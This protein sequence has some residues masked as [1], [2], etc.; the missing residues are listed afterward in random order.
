MSI[1]HAYQGGC[2]CLDKEDACI[3]ERALMQGYALT[4]YQESFSTNAIAYL[5]DWFSR[6]NDH[7]GCMDRAKKQNRR[8]LMCN[9]LSYRLLILSGLLLVTL[10]RVVVA[11]ENFPSDALGASVMP[12]NIQFTTLS[13]SDGLSQ[14]AINSIVQDRQG[15]IWIGTQEGLNRYDGYEFTVYQSNPAEPGS[16][17]HDWVWTV[18]VDDAGQLWVGTDGGGLNR[19]EPDTG[20]F[21]HFRHNPDDSTSLSGNRVR[22]IYQDRQGFFWIGTDGNG[23]NRF[24]PE[25]GSFVHYRHDPTKSDSLANDKVLA[26]YEDNAGMMWIGTEGGL[27]RFYRVSEKFFHYAND[28]SRPDSLSDDRVRSL[29]EDS[30]GQFW[31]GTENGLNLLQTDGSFKRFQHNPKHPY[32]LSHNVVRTLFQDNSGALWV[33]TE[34][35]LDEWRPEVQGFVHNSHEPE[36]PSSI[37]NDRVTTVF[38]DNGGVLWIGT[39]NGISRWNYISDAFIY[40]KDDTSE[41]SGLSNNL[42]TGISE[43]RDGSVWIGTYGG[44]LNRLDPVSGQVVRFRHDPA[45]QNTLSDDRVMS[46]FT[47]IDGNVWI[48]TRNAGLNRLNLKTGRFTHYRHDPENKHTLSGNG[49][50]AIYGDGDGTLWVGVYDGG[51]NRLDLNSGEFFAFRHDP[52]DD[53][54]LSSDRVLSISAGSNG[55]LWIGTEDGGVNQFNKM[56][57]SFTQYRHDPEDTS[58]LSSDTAWDILEGRDGSLYVATRD[59]GFNRWLPENRKAGKAVFNRYGKQNGLISNLIYGALEDADGILWMSSNRGLIRLDPRNGKTRVFDKKNGLQGYEFN[60]GAHFRSLNGSLLFGGTD[61]LVMFHP[62]RVRSNLHHP[63]VSVTA[64]LHLHPV[65]TG[66]SS[67]AQPVDLTIGYLDYSISFEFTALDYTSSDKNQY[68]YMLEGFDNEWLDPGRFRRVTYTNLPAG[69]YTF[70]VKASNNDG[71]WSQSAAAV[72]LQVTPPP[73][74]TGLAYAIY[75][76]L[77]VGLVIVVVL[78]Q[79]NKLKQA[80]EQRKELEKQVK[81]RTQ[82]LAERNQDLERLTLQLEET[83][84]TDPLTGLKN[85]RYLDQQL[86]S[87]IAALHREGEEQHQLS[88]SVS[89]LDLSPNLYFIMID[90]DGF[91][92][93]NDTYGHHAGDL[94]L[95][96]VRDILQNCCR[97]SDTIIRWGGDEFF[98]VGRHASRLYAEKHAER[99]RAELANHQY[100][101]GGGHVARLSGSIGL[102]IFPF[103]PH[104]S[105]L[106]SWEQVATIADKAAYLAKENGRNAWVGL[107]GT[108]RITGED[109]YKQVTMD[110][111]GQIN[112]GM[113]EITTSIKKP[114][115][116]T[117]RTQLNN[118]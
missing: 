82:E 12:R 90:L 2:F 104:K 109:I 43:S 29:Y 1:H 45:D 67:D 66:H 112:R 85:R 62:E 52:N 56:T 94:A 8:S 113:V 41:I 64:F 46:V 15:F 101:V 53:S 102:T 30:H 105:K 32:S 70:K 98:I 50:T 37:S 6:I 27:D 74:K 110:L 103:A 116:L 26:I 40:Y 24:N 91:K 77:I 60:F 84:V 44:G 19:Y 117:N 36:N 17:S 68:L 95:K 57:Q 63:P 13:V 86:E 114:L 5:T 4:G 78:T 18:F 93:I 7:S 58:S 23:L 49:V 47:D 100:Q 111:E 76:I 33:G 61:G 38:Q 28:P 14:A 81:L 75:V 71:V 51:L 69:S 72:N 22:V 42:V 11:A 54:T 3:T 16:L 48:G 31:V 80:A 39:Y 87:E 25:D 83:S 89:T 55:V 65:A 73:W 88:P 99:I 21:T 97:K 35:G 10:L 59:G 9:F 106:L 118:A 96:Q 79:V 92:P 20:R 107:Y 115:E 34:G 108:H